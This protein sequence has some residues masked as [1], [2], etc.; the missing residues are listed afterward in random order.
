MYCRRC[1]KDDVGSFHRCFMPGA[2]SR[3]IRPLKQR[4][5]P[6]TPLSRKLARIYE[7]ELGEKFPG[8]IENAVVKREGSAITPGYVRSQGA[9]VWSLGVIDGDR[10]LH[11]FGSQQAATFCAKAGKVLDE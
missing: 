4:P 9:W 8:G 10:R 5:Q 2:T 7:Q 6:N 11:E 1:D 3:T